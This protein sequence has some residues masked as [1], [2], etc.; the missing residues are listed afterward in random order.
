MCAYE[1]FGETLQ[2]GDCKGRGIGPTREVVVG[3]D[4]GLAEGVGAQKLIGSFG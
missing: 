3:L 2:A 4:L 1:V